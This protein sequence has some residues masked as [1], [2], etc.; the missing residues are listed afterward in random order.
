MNQEL[1]NFSDCKNN[2]EVVCKIFKL[3]NFETT[4]QNMKNILEKNGFEN[5]HSFENILNKFKKNN[6]LEKV[7]EVST[8]SKNGKKIYTPMYRMNNQVPIPATRK[9]ANI[10]YNC[11]KSIFAQ[12]QWKISKQN[13]VKI[14]KKANVENFSSFST[15]ISVLKNKGIVKIVGKEQFKDIHGRDRLSP[16]YEWVDKPVSYESGLKKTRMILSN[17]TPPIHNNEEDIV[18]VYLENMRKGL[19]EKFVPLVKSQKELQIAKKELCEILDENKRLRTEIEIKN[20]II[21][22]FKKKVNEQ[23]GKVISDI[24]SYFG[25]HEEKIMNILS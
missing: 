20:N 6:I 13:L 4:I 15:G 12:N 7:G 17:G 18:D 10:I 14:L 9:K 22:G 3:N 1:I 16:I 19:V 25:V 11:L 24:A 8:F 5:I 21:D 23:C 2:S